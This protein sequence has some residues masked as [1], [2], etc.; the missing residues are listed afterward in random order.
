MLGEGIYGLTF[1]DPRR[2]VCRADENGAAALHED[3][4]ALAIL[5]NGKILGSDR[6][7]GV[8]SGTYFFDPLSGCNRVQVRLE[9]PPEGE[10]FTGFAAGNEGASLEIVAAF[11][12]A[13]TIVVTTVDIAGHPVDVELA[14]IG[15]LPNL[16]Y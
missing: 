9:L 8:F 14:Y 2:G 4:E 16:G 3:A 10:L 12:R 1:K 6:W 11:D 5:R 7:G 15:P 13:E